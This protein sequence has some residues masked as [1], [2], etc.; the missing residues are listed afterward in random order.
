MPL[1]NET[2]EEINDNIIENDRKLKETDF[3]D[4]IMSNHEKLSGHPIAKECF[5]KYNGVLTRDARRS[6]L[7]I[8]NTAISMYR[9]EYQYG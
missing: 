3:I 9:D 2:F 6:V 4:N 5:R 7:D 8:I 1:P